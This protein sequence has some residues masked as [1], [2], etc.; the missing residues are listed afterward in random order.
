MAILTIIFT[1][2]VLWLLSNAYALFRNRQVAVKSGLPLLTCIM[3]PSNILYLIFNAPMRPYMEKV[4]PA[5]I[6]DRILPT[7]YGWEFFDRYA[8]HEKFGWTFILATPGP[9][10]VWTADP[11]VASQILTRRKDFNSLHMSGV[12]M[13]VFGPNMISVSNTTYR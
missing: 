12:I 3:N 11:D 4:L 8:L 13:G 5:A 2:T 6:F 10:I 1:L 7:V 9:N